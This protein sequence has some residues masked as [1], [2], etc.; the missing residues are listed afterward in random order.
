ML[1][2]NRRKEN[3]TKCQHCSNA[4]SL[5]Q[6]WEAQSWKHCLAF[7]KHH[8]VIEFLKLKDTPS[9][10]ED[11]T[12]ISDR[13]L[14]P[15]C[16][17]LS[18]IWR[19]VACLLCCNTRYSPLASQVTLL[20][21]SRGTVVKSFVWIQLQPSIHLLGGSWSTAFQACDA[22][23]ALRLLQALKDGSLKPFH[24][25]VCLHTWLLHLLYPKCPF[26]QSASAEVFSLTN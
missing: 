21:I 6:L 24:S 3:H 17:Y 16:L 23:L 2:L 19:T 20:T 26:C 1:L 8:D 18:Q 14:H 5:I 12:R 25:Q 4:Q 7:T 22:W 9:Y 13:P 11:T 10:L 15:V